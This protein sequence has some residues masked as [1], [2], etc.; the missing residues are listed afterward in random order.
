MNAE[1]DLAEAY[2]EWR[3][4]AEAEGAAIGAQNWSLVAASQMAL[5]QLQEQITRLSVAARKEW[6]KSGCNLPAKENNLK[7]TIQELIALE[8]R[9]QTLL[10]SIQEATRA[11][12]AQL[13]R[14]GRN[15]KQIHR[16]YRQIQP[17]AW[18]SFS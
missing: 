14:A 15:L 2:Q 9:N 3:R 4:L 17:A 18:T 6:L 11:T 8:Q 13:N 5:H 10:G 7:A 1:R 16:T 12:L